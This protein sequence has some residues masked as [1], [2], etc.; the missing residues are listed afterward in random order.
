MHYAVV[1]VYRSQ[2]K[3][4]TS[5]ADIAATPLSWFSDEPTVGLLTRF[6]WLPSQCSVRLKRIVPT[7]WAPTAHISVAERADT[8]YWELSLG[9]VLGLL[10]VRQSS[11][12]GGVDVLVGVGVRVGVW[13]YELAAVGAVVQVW[14]IVGVPTEAAA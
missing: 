12:Q 6:H 2:F 11:P 14:V 7:R 10:T 1:F 3:Y 13:V 9:S 8:A 4:H 5:L